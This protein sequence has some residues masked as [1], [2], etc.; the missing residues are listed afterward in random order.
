MS[1]SRAAKYTVGV[2]SLSVGLYGYFYVSSMM[3]DLNKHPSQ[4]LYANNFG[5]QVVAFLLTR[6]IAAVLV[7]CIALVIESYFLNKQ[8]DNNE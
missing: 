7:L 8:N 2:W 6:G 5:F 4:D 1:F 3:A